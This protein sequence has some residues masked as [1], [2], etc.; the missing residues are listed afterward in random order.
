MIK[1]VL[2]LFCITMFSIV[3]SYCQSESLKTP[4][5]SL[6]LNRV[7]NDSS[8]YYFS[9]FN[10]LKQK[11]STSLPIGVFDS[12]TGGLTVLDAILGF[13]NFD[14]T[15]NK[16]HQKGDGIKDFINEQFIYF[17]DQANMPYGNYPAMNK[18][19][20]LKE[21]ILR[22]ALF[23][24]GN[25]SYKSALDTA[26]QTNKQSVKLIVVAC[27]TATAYGKEDIEKMLSQTQSKIKVIGVIDAGVRGALSTFRLN[28]S[29]TVAVIATAGT[30]SSDGYKNAFFD[31]ITNLGF[32]GD[33]E[34]I[35]QSGMG[36][37]EAI[38]EES[39]FIDR[40]AR[41]IRKNYQGPSMNSQNWKIQEELLSVYN[42]DTTGNS[43]LYKKNNGKYVE[44]QLNSP[45]NYIRFYLV[46]LCEQLKKKPV[47]NPLKTLIL[48][49]THYPFYASF[50]QSTLNELYN[51]KINGNHIYRDVLS[52]SI[53][54]IDPALNTAKEVHEYLHVNELLNRDQNVKSNQ[55]YISVPDL[56][57]H[58]IEID[59]TLNLTYTY[60]YSRDVNHFY[61]TK[62]VP[63]SNR[64]VN[65]EILQRLQNQLPEIYEMIKEFERETKE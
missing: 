39:N 8:D 15:K 55:F 7:L 3:S 31:Q 41:G 54:L 18:T 32:K 38:D 23:L 25:K 24:L 19:A 52:D 26:W 20:F 45:E 11:L 56:N 59:T 46:N 47:K 5:A 28:E 29:G 48:G 62:H 51:L 34:F 65:K 50:F 40:N 30:V 27:N 63:M 17:G 12:G 43:L 61:D 53:I 21:L 22:D 33:F 10:V 58:N 37:A 1:K 4:D 14:V 42:F 60:K 16:Y 6:F 57:C 49:C 13:D 36:I 44:I 9:D 2:L 64:T 35:Q